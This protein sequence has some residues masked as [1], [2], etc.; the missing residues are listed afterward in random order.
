MRNYGQFVQLK[1]KANIYDQKD[2]HKHKSRQKR[3]KKGRSVKVV[4]GDSQ[5]KKSTG[6]IYQRRFICCQIFPG[7]KADDTE[8]YLIPH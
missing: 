1:T 5:L 7:P 3:N 2:Q 6:A 8:G 4:A